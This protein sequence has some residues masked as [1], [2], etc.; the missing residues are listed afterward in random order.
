ML[1]K[2]IHKH[3]PSVRDVWVWT[4][5]WGSP[6]GR[7]QAHLCIHDK[8]SAIL[9]AQGVESDNLGSTR[10]R[11]ARPQ[12]GRVWVTS[13]NNLRSKELTLCL[14]AAMTKI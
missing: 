1:S 6:S 11:V 7:V 13:T 8:F 2:K 10:S 14:T 4:I 5:K 3:G 9:R 12:L